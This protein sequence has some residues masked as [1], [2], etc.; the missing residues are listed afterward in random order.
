MPTVA[1]EAMMH[2]V[3]CLVSDA[4]GTAAYIRHGEDG[5]VFPSGDVQAL[6]S[7]CVVHRPPRAGGSDGA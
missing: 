2:G 5:L 1:A 3:P 6:R 7:D 4:V